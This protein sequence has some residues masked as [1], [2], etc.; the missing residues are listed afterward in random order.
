M[1]N[2]NLDQMAREARRLFGKTD[3]GRAFADLA[4][5]AGPVAHRLAWRVLGDK[6][7]ADDAMQET[8][9]KLADKLDRYDPGLPFV[10]WLRRIATRAALDLQRRENVVVTLP[11]TAAGEVEAGGG[12]VAAK[13]DR[14]LLARVLGELSEHQRTVFVLR[15]LEGMTTA[16]IGTQLG[17][18]ESTVR[19]HLA[20]ARQKVRSRWQEI[21]SPERKTDEM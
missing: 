4:R 18:A 12:V 20:R 2:R 15:D 13:S 11:L 14:E 6:S 19:V 10:P 1:V 5:A 8:L 16:E 21:N 7:L 9:L 17:L 3:G